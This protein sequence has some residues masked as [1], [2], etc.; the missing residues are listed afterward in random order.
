MKYVCDVCGWEYDEDRYVRILKLKNSNLHNL[1]TISWKKSVL[2]RCT[3]LTVY[4]I[5]AKRYAV[6]EAW[7]V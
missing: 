2:L 3:R 4:D 5:I 7:Y 6:R 1:F